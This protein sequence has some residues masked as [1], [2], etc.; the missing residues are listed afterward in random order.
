MASGNSGECLIGQHSENRS[1]RIGTNK[2]NNKRIPSLNS[3]FWK[4]LIFCNIFL[5]IS[6]G[7]GHVADFL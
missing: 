5:T 7:G 1:V 6:G 4:N 2:K 3:V